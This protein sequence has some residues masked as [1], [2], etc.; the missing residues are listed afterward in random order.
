MRAFTHDVES[1]ELTDEECDAYA[2]LVQFACHAEGQ[3]KL[4]LWLADTTRPQPSSVQDYAQRQARFIW[5]TELR[6]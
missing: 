6:V 1:V 4:A 2:T 5:R 3:H